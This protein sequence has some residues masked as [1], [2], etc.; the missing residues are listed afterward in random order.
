[1]SVA[2]A[3]HTQ[4]PVPRF[5]IFVQKAPGHECRGEVNELL[6]K[7]CRRSTSLPIAAERIDVMCVA[8]TT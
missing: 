8:E 3:V 7:V 6:T 1:M 5:R 2:R 4:R